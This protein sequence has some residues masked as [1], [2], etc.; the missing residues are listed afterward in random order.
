MVKT[1]FIRLI[2]CIALAGYNDNDNNNDDADAATN[3]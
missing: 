1:H 2:E 3:M